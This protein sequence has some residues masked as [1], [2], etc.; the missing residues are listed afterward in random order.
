MSYNERVHETPA[1]LA[2]LQDLLDAGYEDAGSHLR[3]IV[4]PDR[5]LTAA[6]VC[7]LMVGVQVLVLATVTRDGRPLVG[8]VDGL[9]YRGNF[10]FG[11][12]FDSVRFRHLGSRRSLSAGHVRGERLA[13][14][15]H[16]SAADIAADRDQ[17]AGFQGYCLATYGADWPDWGGPAAYAR[18]E[19]DKMFAFSFEKPA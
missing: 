16:G 14:T 8:P 11:S 7:D 18:I 12:S 2:A 19:P 15:I 10:W 17:Q 6:Q 4:T 3:S 1:D 13:V 9:F 5:R